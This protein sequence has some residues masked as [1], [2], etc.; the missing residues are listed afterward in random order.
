MKWINVQCLE[1]FFEDL[2]KEKG[3]PGGFYRKKCVTKYPEY[4]WRCRVE[5][6][7]NAIKHRRLIALRSK[8]PHMKKREIAWHILIY[9]LEIMQKLRALIV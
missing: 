1:Q 9:N 3:K 7:F 4:N 5:S 8:E 6:A 2:G